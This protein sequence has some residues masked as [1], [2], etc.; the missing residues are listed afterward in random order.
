MT[1]LSGKVACV[2]GGSG[3][4]G[5]EVC[6]ML[7]AHGA[8]VAFTYRS[9]GEVARAVE[10]EILGHGRRAL[11]LHVDFSDAAEVAGCVAQ[12]IETFG[13]LDILVHAAGGTVEW[14][15][16]REVSDTEWRSFLEID[17][18]GAFTAIREAVRHMHDNGGGAIVAVSSIAAQMCQA[19]NAQGAASKAGLEALIR[20]VAREEGRYNIRANAVAIGL[21]DTE[22]ARIAFARWGEAA[23]DRVVKGI[24]LGR[25]ATPRDVGEMVLFLV[26]DKGAYVTGKVIQVDG[27]QVISG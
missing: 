23:S 27:G 12:A 9:G 24:P 8:D 13:R 11:P 21:T 5:R 4:V 19:R 20:V 15:P 14:A 26:S 25:I 2:T 6:T 10:R 22:Q 16:V 3:G 18:S 17:L 1:D 7:A